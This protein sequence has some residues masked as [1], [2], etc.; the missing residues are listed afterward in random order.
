[1]GDAAMQRAE[2]YTEERRGGR[3]GGADGSGIEGADPRATWARIN[4]A[5]WTGKGKRGGRYLRA[6]P[7]RTGIDTDE[8]GLD[9]PTGESILE[10]LL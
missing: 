6:P 8:A 1:M 2:G 4:G 5:S 10:V 9:Q 3:E 7:T